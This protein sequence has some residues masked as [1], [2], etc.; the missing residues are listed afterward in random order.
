ME[1]TMNLPTCPV[2]HDCKNKCHYSETD[3]GMV[4]GLRTRRKDG[5]FE[6]QNFDPIQIIDPDDLPEPDIE[7]FPEFDYTQ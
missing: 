4:C 5:L 7:L 3:P 2:K 1:M 6:C